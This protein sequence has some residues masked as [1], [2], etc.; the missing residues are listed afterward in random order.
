MFEC[1][2]AFLDLGWG[3]ACYDE[4]CGSLRSLSAIMS[5]PASKSVR[6]PTYKSLRGREPDSFV[7]HASDQDG[8]STNGL[9]ER[10]GY[11]QGLGL[12]TELRFC[13]CG[14]L[15]VRSLIQIE[16]ICS[17]KRV[18]AVVGCD[19]EMQVILVR[20]AARQLFS[21]NILVKLGLGIPDRL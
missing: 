17:P 20:C 1:F 12:V 6:L 3:A 5:T 14:H 9:W 19:T 7:V 11:F 2:D 21:I 16:V 8:L 15:P 13:G 18:S 4:V 10:L